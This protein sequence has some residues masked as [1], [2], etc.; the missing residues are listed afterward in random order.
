MVGPRS[1]SGASNQRASTSHAATSRFLHY[2]KLYRMESSEARNGHDSG[3]ATTDG[4]LVQEHE[5]QHPAPNE[6]L[7][8]C[9]PG[10]PNDLLSSNALH[11]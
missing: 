3:S 10:S 5:D 1:L 8:I 2:L 9:Q 4:V 6:D 7:E 11:V